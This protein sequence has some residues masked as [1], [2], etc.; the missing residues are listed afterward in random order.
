MAQ[1][2]RALVSLGRLASAVPLCC[3]RT[4]RCRSRP[5]CPVCSTPPRRSD[6]LGGFVWL[7]QT[8]SLLRALGLVLGFVAW[9]SWPSDQA[10]FK[11]G[12]DHAGS[13]PWGLPGGD[14]VLRHSANATRRYLVRAGADGDGW[15]PD[16]REPPMPLPL[17]VAN[18]RSCQPGGLGQC[19]VPGLWRAPPSRWSCTPQVAVARRPHTGGVGHLPDPR[20]RDAVGGLFLHEQVSARMFAGGAVVML[21]WRWPWA[22]WSEVALNPALNPRRPKGAVRVLAFGLRGLVALPQA[23]SEFFPRRQHDGFSP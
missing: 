13:G 7:R 18:G 3:S 4:R 12:D 23:L 11:A 6:G 15:Q 5:V 22:D 14:A 21:A 9:P 10:S 19:V 20:V 1:H 16:R 2:W 17:A 8:L